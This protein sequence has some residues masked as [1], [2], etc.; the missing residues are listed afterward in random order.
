M[1]ISREIARGLYTEFRDKSLLN[2]KHVLN[3]TTT[4]LTYIAYQLYIK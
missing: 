1:F 2:Y 4:H 3:L